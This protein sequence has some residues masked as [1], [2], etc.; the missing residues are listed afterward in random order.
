MLLGVSCFA[1]LLAVCCYQVKESPHLPPVPFTCLMIGP[2][3]SLIHREIALWYW[4]L[5]EMCTYA[6][7]CLGKGTCA[8]NVNG[9]GR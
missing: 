3:P 5:T 8:F 7:T 6:S 4:T 1:E 9:W 2:T